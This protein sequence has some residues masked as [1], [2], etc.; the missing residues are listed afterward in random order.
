MRNPTTEQPISEAIPLVNALIAEAERNCIDI[1]CVH[2]HALPS[3][4]F[5]I[6]IYAYDGARDALCDLF[7]LHA[8]HEHFDPMLLLDWDAPHTAVRRV[9]RWLINSESNDTDFPFIDVAAA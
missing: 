7:G 5:D 4:R 2:V 6:A 3:G 9:G 8:L 1:S